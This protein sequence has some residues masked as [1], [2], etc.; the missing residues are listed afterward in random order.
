MSFPARFLGE[1]PEF[2]VYRAPMD[3]LPAALAERLE[4]YRADWS[5]GR[6]VAHLSAL[7]GLGDGVGICDYFLPLGEDMLAVDKTELMSWMLD[8]MAAD[9][10]NEMAEEL[11]RKHLRKMSGSAEVLD[12]L[13]AKFV[14]AKGGRKNPPQAPCE[15]WVA[16][17]DIES[18]KGDPVAYDALVDRTLHILRG[19]LSAPYVLV[20]IVDRDIFA[21]DLESRLPAE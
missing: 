5:P 21:E 18:Q 7:S 1:V 17:T 12:A 14:A 8:R 13:Y 19:E 6:G 16:A 20:S 3:F 11:S 9:D 15:F 10:I 2:Q 4:S